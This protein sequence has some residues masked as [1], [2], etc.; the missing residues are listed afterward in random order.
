MEITNAFIGKISQPTSTE[1]T[2]AL[3][4]TADLWQQLIDWLAAKQGVTEQD[5]KPVYPHKYGWSVKMKFKKRTIVYLGPCDGCFRAS[6]ILGDK[7]VAAARAA[8]LSISL[9]KRIDEARRY[10]EGTGVRLTVKR[11]ADL[12]AV[13]ALVQIKLAN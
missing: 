13:R 6:F 7:A 4:T 2:A 11:A 9:M 5:W 8:K 1:I 10:P 3:G 12:A